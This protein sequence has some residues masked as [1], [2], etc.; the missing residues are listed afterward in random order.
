MLVNKETQNISMDDLPLILAVNRNAEPLD[1]INYKDCAYQYAKNN[2]AWSLGTYEV[3]LRGGINAKTGKQSTLVMDTIVALDNDTSPYSYKKH[4][5]ALTNKNLFARD[6]F[7]CAYCGYVHGFNSLSR[8]HI[9]P[10]SRGGDDTWLNCV[11][12]CKVCNNL[13]CNNLLSELHWEL[14]YVP[15][16][17]NFAEALLLKN[18]N[19]LADQREFLLKKIPKNSRLMS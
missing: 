1:W 10:I 13:K 2:V 18:R 12:A 5:P 15:F 17:P 4:A 9:V 16:T 3:V 19:I 14:L 7:C 6:N 11:T 8:D